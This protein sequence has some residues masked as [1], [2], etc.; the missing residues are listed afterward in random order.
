LLVVLAKDWKLI[1]LA[2]VGFF[3]VIKKMPTGR[4]GEDD[5]EEIS[6]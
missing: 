5:P 6:G 1:A 4:L 2:A 3:G